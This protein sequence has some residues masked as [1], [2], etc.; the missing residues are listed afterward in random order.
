MRFKRRR[1][2]VSVLTVLALAGLGGLGV[3]AQEPDCPSPFTPPGTDNRDGYQV[4]FEEAPIHPMELSSD[5]SELWVANIPDGSV[6]VF[7]ID[8][9]GQLT[10]ATEIKVGLGPVTIRRRPAG[11]GGLQQ[12][13][14]V[15]QRAVSIEPNEPVEPQEPQHEMWVVCHSSNSLYVI[16]EATKR[17]VATVRT[18]FEPS[19]LVFD[20][21]GSTAYVT[22][23]ASNQV[24]RVAAATRTVL[25]PS[26]E[27]ESEMPPGT[28]RFAH[29]E[30]PRSLLLE[31]DS[32]FV[33]SFKSGN[34][35]IRDSNDLDTD[36]ET[37]DIFNIW[38]L[39]SPLPPD[40]D[41]LELDVT[42]PNQAGNAVLWRM[43]TLNFDLKRGGPGSEV[44][45]ST[46]DLL[47]D[48][49]EHKFDYKD[50]GFSIH[51]V[52][53]ATPSATNGP[54]A[55]TT[56]VD[57]NDPAN[58]HAGLPASY[59]CAVPNEM[60]FASDGSALYV[61]CYETRNT[62]VIDPAT[63][64]VV[65]QLREIPTSRR[66]FGPRGVVLNEADGVL[67]VYNRADN[68]V[69]VFNVPVA[70]GSTT[71]PVQNVDAGYDI[72]PES[73]LAGRRHSINAANSGTGLESCNTCHMDGKLDGLAWDLADFTGDLPGDP[74]P[75][76]DNNI[77]VT[78]DLRGIEETPIY[79][80]QGNRDD[81]IAFNAAFDGLLGGT[82]LSQ[83]DFPDFQRFIFALSYPPNPHV[84]GGQSQ[85]AAPDGPGRVYSTNAVLG[86]GCFTALTAHTVSKDTTEFPAFGGTP[87][88][89]LTCNDCHSMDG[90]SGTNNQVNNDVRNI[91][92]EDATQLRGLFDKE[93]DTVFY[94]GI[95]IPATGFGFGSN[96]ITNTVAEFVDIF[97][98]FNATQ[99]A[100]ITGFLDEFDSGMAPSTAFAWTMTKANVGP[101]GTVPLAPVLSYQIPEAGAGNSD[102][103]VRGFLN[104]GGGPSAAIGMLYSS[105]TS[106]FHTDTTGVG[107]FT[108]TQL[109]GEVRTNGGVLTFVGVPSGMGYRLGRDRDMDFALDGDE[110]GLGT[111]VLAADTDGD[112]FP[113]GYEVRLGSNPTNPASVPPA[114]TVA[115]V[116]ANETLA[117]VNSEVAKVRWT[118][119]EEATSRVRVIDQATSTEV[120]RGDEGQ[121]KKQHVMVV[122][123]LEPG[124]NYDLI[125]EGDDPAQPT[126]TGS[127]TLLTGGGGAGTQPH[128]F[129]S[130]HIATTTLTT[131]S[132][133]C[134]LP[135]GPCFYRVVASFTVVDQDDQPVSG[136]T[137]KA[138][139]VEWVTGLGTQPVQTATTGPSNASGVASVA[140]TTQLQVGSGGTAEVIADLTDE[141]VTI[142]DTNN[143]LYFHP[144]DGEFNYWA[145][146]PLP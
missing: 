133:I 24:A 97:Q 143:R 14:S 2:A 95:G 130:V 119:D 76:D 36:G 45:V 58:V 89:D 33:L 93:S 18:A 122:R 48:L 117:W 13:A 137:V 65:A 138:R 146:V 56:I 26:M 139:L 35:T 145:Q 44:Y 144:L 120:W 129:S 84:D 79:H 64:T 28:A 46:V 21:S 53:H 101:P 88:K 87:T 105:R 71:A 66:G 91:L 31:G 34:G 121:F 103:V 38:T 131:T 123:G 124:R 63:D 136:A 73:V 50:N 85:P 20:A 67:Y 29:V 113:D 22:L 74:E 42:N 111:S 102:L 108:F 61:A 62:V 78:M 15:L 83:Q 16:D 1:A 57:L 141:K 116:V 81:L 135:S 32:L 60:A 100:R 70:G 107:P 55:T 127:S 54:Q 5:G 86:F 96:H 12:Q 98:N 69:S 118:T 110:P 68:T 115:P 125:I 43:G 52:V 126:N 94:G 134:T 17:V 104:L 128:L 6:S 77:K 132:T 90:F 140:F 3:G 80:W 11:P 114:E 142:V 112:T 10:L 7:D 92:A 82:E 23:S 47:N 25:S 109:V 51:A 49:R 30:E 8:A 37:N 27:V 41:V 59:R 39:G 9:S 40:R 106:S 75:R 4:L 72:T 99:R 19:G